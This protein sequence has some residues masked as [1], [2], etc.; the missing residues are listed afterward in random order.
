[1]ALTAVSEALEE[2]WVVPKHSHEI[3]DLQMDI[4]DTALS[5]GE[6]TTLA[7]ASTAAGLVDT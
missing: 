7:A 5:V 1:M 4:I 6:L 2:R 3:R